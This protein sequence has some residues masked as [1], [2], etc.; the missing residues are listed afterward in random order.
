VLSG[1]K[2]L[3]VA[4]QRFFQ[5]PQ[6]TFPADD[7]RIHHLREDHQVASGIIGT[8]F[9]SLFSRLNMVP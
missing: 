2:D 6:G 7:E 4:G 1:E 9:N 5:S 3:L 8:R